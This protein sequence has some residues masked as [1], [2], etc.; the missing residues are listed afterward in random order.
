MDHTNEKKNLEEYGSERAE[1]NDEPITADVD[2]TTP[3]IR[4]G[5]V[6]MLGL[7]IAAIIGLFFIHPQRPLSEGSYAMGNKYPVKKLQNYGD[8]NAL[9]G[10]SFIEIDEIIPIAANSVMNYPYASNTQ[11]SYQTY[12]TTDYK[13]TNPYKYKVTKENTIPAS[14]T[15]A[16]QLMAVVDPSTNLVYF[17]E[18]NESKVTSNPKLDRFAEEAKVKG[19]DINV[20]AYTDPRG[21]RE[22]N[23]R[24]SER[25]ANA[26][27]KYLQSQGISPN[28]IKAKGMGPTDK[29]PNDAQ[30]RRAVLS[31][32]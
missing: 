14:V 32:E 12:K 15:P 17:F 1:F 18:L 16:P 28:H 30:D 19:A 8:P 9:Q 29:Y 27:A 25:R 31:F 13:A 24:L 7:I 11:K 23:Q 5:A 21:N 6:A 20:V 10:I 26:I 4:W 22:Y 2:N 3:A